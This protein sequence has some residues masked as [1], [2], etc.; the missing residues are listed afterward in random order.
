MQVK[1]TRASG[2]ACGATIEQR[3]A[4]ESFRYALLAMIDRLRGT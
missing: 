4:A 1:E 3:G 2:H